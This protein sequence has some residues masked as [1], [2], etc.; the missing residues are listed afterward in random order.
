VSFEG[1]S[2]HV[3]TPKYGGQSL[4]NYEVALTKLVDACRQLG[5]RYNYSATYNES[6]ITRAR[7]R[8]VDEYLKTDDC[9]HA[10]FIDAD[11]GFEVGDVLHM[12]KLDLDIAAAPCVKK[13][14]NWERVRKALEK[15]GHRF[16]SEELARVGGDYVFNAEPFDGTRT[17]EISQPLEMRQVGTGLMMIRRN[18]F[19]KFKDEY[20]ERWYETRND[21]NSQPGPTWDFFRVG[22]DPETREYSSE[23]YCFCDD[24]RAIGF[25]VWLCPWVRTTHQGTYTFIGDIPAVRA[26]AGGL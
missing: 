8:L 6:L 26:L 23:D 12:L 3:L 14:I 20:P 24:S 9:S 11:I 4:V 1:R 22:I 7:N 13:S 17:F 25:K 16:S 10:L 15:N 5:L 19:E 21:P 18:V 2:L